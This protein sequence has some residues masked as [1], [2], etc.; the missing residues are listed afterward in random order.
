MTSPRLIG[1]F[2]YD[3][4]KFKL[5]NYWSSWDFT[6]IMFRRNWKLLFIQIFA[7]NGF[8]LC[9]RP[10]F[11]ISKLL[12]DVAFTW[13]PRELCW[14]K[15]WLILGKFAIWTVHVLEK[16]Y[17]N[18]FEFLER[19]INAFVAKLR[20]MQVFSSV[21]FRPPCWCPSRKGSPY[22]S[23]QIWKKNPPH[24]LLKKIAVT[25]NLGESLCIF[26]IF[27]FPDSELYL[28]NGFDFLFWMEWHW[29]PAVSSFFRFP[30]KWSILNKA[31]Y[32][33]YWEL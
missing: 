29:K 9:H 18:A 14:L 12:G 27:L 8:L 16:Y 13:R 7:P 32:L 19:S 4:T 21:G 25:V 33:K 23:L 30:L 3:V 24:I 31:L 20:D 11:G 10:H 28:L 1:G 6:L 22:K 5:Q 15:E 26:T 17:F 2:S